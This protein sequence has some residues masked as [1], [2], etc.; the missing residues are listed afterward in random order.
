MTSTVSDY[1]STMCEGAGAGDWKINGFIL[2]ALVCHARPGTELKHRNVCVFVVVCVLFN[3]IHSG[4]FYQSDP[5][6]RNRNYVNR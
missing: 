2:F 6:L 1:Q 4:V 3:F 5:L